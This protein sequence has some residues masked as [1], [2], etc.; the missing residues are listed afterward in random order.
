[1]NMLSIW[2]IILGGTVVTY[3]IR[4]SF[5]AFIPQERVPAL[6]Q[7]GLRYVPPAVLAALITPE[8][9]RPTGT[10]DISFD[11][12]RLIAGIFAAIVAW[13]TRNTWLTIL[14]GMAVLWLLSGI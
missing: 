13:R 11:N 14:I 1:M 9:L 2:G 7:R 5:I 4:L 3:A 6:F 8:L 12:P 10:L